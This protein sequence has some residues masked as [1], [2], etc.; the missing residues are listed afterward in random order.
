MRNLTLC[1]GR[2]KKQKSELPKQLAEIYP[3]KYPQNQLARQK[4]L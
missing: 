2:K 4:A 1:V 3:Q